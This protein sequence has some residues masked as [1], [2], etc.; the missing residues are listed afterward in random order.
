MLSATLRFWRD[1]RA[2]TA[3]SFALMLPLLVSGMGL[4]V[5][6][7]NYR[8]V[9]SRLQTA[10]DVAAL[11]AV[12]DSKANASTKVSTAISYVAGNIPTDYGNVTTAADVTLG[13]YTTKDG[14]KPDN[15]AAANAVRVIAK[16]SPD[17]GNAAPRI[18][19]AFLSTESM[20]ITATAI[21][22]RPTNVF[23]EPPEVTTLQANAGDFNEL[24]AYCYDPVT[25]TRG[26]LNLIGNNNRRGGITGMPLH[27]SDSSKNIKMPSTTNWPTCT[28]AGQSVSFYLRNFIGANGSP[29]SLWT[30]TV[31]NYYTD[32]V[33][34]GGVESSGLFGKG[35]LVETILCPSKELCTPVESG[36][37]AN[38]M[39]ASKEGVFR[40]ALMEKSACEPGKY[41][42]YGWEDRPPPGG[43]K[44]YNDMRMVLRCPKSGKLG[45]SAPRLVS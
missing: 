8:L 28:G 17:R 25:K 42:Y 15:S 45:D 20:T 35:K 34:T 40:D 22:A 31:N 10:A 2:A 11:S 7:S 6:Y 26:P 33:L 18:F 44:D 27:P 12:A 36:G 4:A 41:M 3:V 9:Q 30:T 21:A 14:F 29:N 23:Y 32:T 1:R 38:T 39:V 19:S 5:D 43:D 37:P 13:T 16:R 24:Y